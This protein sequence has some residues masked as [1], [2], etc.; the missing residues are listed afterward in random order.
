MFICYNIAYLGGKK[1]AQ[2]K[3]QLKEEDAGIA[4][5]YILRNLKNYKMFDHREDKIK[6]EAERAFEDIVK[7]FNRTFDKDEDK[8]KFYRLL[9][10]WIKEYLDEVQI[11]RLR[12]K[13]RV[14]RT[15]WRKN[16]KQITID[17]K[18]HYRLSEYAKSYNVTLSEAIEKMLDVIEEIE[19]E[20][21]DKEEN[22]K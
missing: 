3:W 15:R 10:K 5:L 16:L 22:I 12:T 21:K 9:K 4:Y 1:M 13:I 17:E 19:R 18:V 8:E 2:H 14:E 20:S 11:K 7:A 6:F